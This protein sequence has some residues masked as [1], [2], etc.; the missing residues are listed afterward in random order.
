MTKPFFNSNRP[1]Q[2]RKGLINIYRHLQNT[3]ARNNSMKMELLSSLASTRLKKY[4]FST[5]IFYR[6]TFY[7]CSTA[8]VVL[9]FFH[10]KKASAAK[11]SE[12]YADA[13]RGNSAPQGRILRY[14]GCI[15]RTTTSSGRFTPLLF[16]STNRLAT[17]L[18][19]TSSGR[20]TLL[21]FYRIDMH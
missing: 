7:S 9:L 4:L 6:R 11:N 5:S 8:E 2:L 3:S 10:M 13:L 21:F 12:V 14:R 1:L 17:R 20:F 19:P 16:F 15:H 18:N